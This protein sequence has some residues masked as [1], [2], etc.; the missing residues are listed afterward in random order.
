MPIRLPIFDTLASNRATVYK[1]PADAVTDCSYCRAPC[2]QLIVDLTDEEAPLYETQE[3]P[4]NPGRRVLKRKEHGYCVYH[5]MET[6]CTIYDRRPTVCSH[7]SCRSDRRIT[8]SLKYGKARPL[9]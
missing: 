2:C 1:T 4:L 7:Y 8:P 9:T 6:G 3:S 5:S